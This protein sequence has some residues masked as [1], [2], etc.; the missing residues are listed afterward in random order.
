MRR[1]AASEPFRDGDAA[2]LTADGAEIGIVLMRNKFKAEGEVRFVGAR[3][4]QDFSISGASVRN[5]FAAALVLNNVVIGGELSMENA[6]VSGQVLVSGA[7]VA[8][9]WDLR[10]AELTHRT[11]PRG[12]FMGAPSMARMPA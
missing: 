4:A 7:R 6:K 5:E 9:N 10:G 1:R 12:A 2:A 8:R 3:I 11:T